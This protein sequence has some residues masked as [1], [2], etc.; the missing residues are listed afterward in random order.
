MTSTSSNMSLSK[1]LLVAPLCVIGLFALGAVLLLF[2]IG[3]STKA[4]QRA[5]QL[6]EFSHS[7]EDCASDA[8]KGLAWA[9]AGFPAARIDSLLKGDV[10]RIDSIRTAIRQAGLLDSIAASRLDTLLGST[11]K[12]LQEMGEV[13]DGDMGFASMYLGTAQEQF[14]SVDSLVG[15][16]V[17]RETSSAELL[18]SR[19]RSSV[20]WLLLIGS[21]VGVALSLYMAR[22]IRGPVAGLQEMASRMSQGDLTGRVE[23]SGSDEIGMLA[24]S[25]SS[26]SARLTDLVR[27][28]RHGVDSLGT[29]LS[30]NVTISGGLSEDADRAKTRSASVAASALE[31]GRTMSASREGVSRMAREMGSVAAGAEEMSAAIAEVTRHADMARRVSLDATRKG[32]DASRKISAL[33]QAVDEIGQVSHLIQAVSSQTR[34]LA[35]NAT[36][37]AARAGEAGR[38]FA[39]VAGEVKNLAHQT[40]GATEQIALKIGQ[41]QEAVRSASS[42]VEG[43]LQVVGEIGSA[44]DSIASSMEQQSASTREIAQRASEASAEMKRVETSAVKGE[45]AAG[46]IQAEIV[47]VD[48]L[49]EGLAASSRQLSQGASRMREVEDVL[50]SGISKFRVS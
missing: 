26:M 28:L 16:A 25:M 33:G 15:V 1:K 27:D 46:S 43:V 31:M 44:I 17:D 45:A 21:A 42:E 38:G 30:E 37:E 10:K 24:G 41:I 34:L 47:D 49:A 39:V 5:T 9:G 3:A 13:T 12:V 2:A 11:H 20:L 35:L 29:S 50:R 7:L 8:Y 18:A 23:V 40:Q 19:M 14:A 22:K 48:R 6:R 36:I 32:G 4:H